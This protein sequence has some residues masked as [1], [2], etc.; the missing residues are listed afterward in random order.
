MVIR[1]KRGGG[2]IKLMKIWKVSRKREAGEKEGRP[3]NKTKRVKGTQGIRGRKK[4]KWKDLY[5]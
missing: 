3:G 4:W 2:W 1:E 5:Q